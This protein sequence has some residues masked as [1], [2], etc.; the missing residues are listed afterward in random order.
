MA[1]TRISG[2]GN[3]RNII[4]ITPESEAKILADNFIAELQYERGA[5]PVAIRVVDP[6]SV[7]NA[8]FE[9]ALA[10]GNED[11]DPEKDADECFWTLTN[12][13]WLNDDNP[14]NDINAVRTSNEAIA[15]RNEQLLLDWGLAITWEQYEYLNPAS[16]DETYT[17]PLPSTIEF[18]DPDQP[19]F[20]G[21][22]DGEG[23][24]NELNWIR[25]GAQETPD[26]TPEEEAVFDD[27]KP[28]NP[29]DEGETWEGVIF[30]TWAPYCMTSWT[31]DI[32]FENGNT[33]PY[34]TVAPTSDD[35]KWNLGPI[36]DAIPGTNNVDVVMTSDKSL[37]TRCPVF[38]MQPN[39]DL[40]QDMDTPLGNPVKMGLRRHASVDKNG[41][42][43]AEGGDA[44]FATLNGQQ[45][46]GMSWFPGYA[47]DVGTGERLNMA[48]GED[49]WASADNGD[50]MIFNPSSRVASFSGSANIYAGG[51]HWIYVFKNQAYDDDNDSRVPAYDQGQYLYGKFGPDAGNND[52]RKAMRG[53][54]WVGSS[55]TNPEF[56]MLPIEEGLIPTETR[57]RLRVAKQYRRYAHDRSDVDDTEGTANNN[58]PL[59]RFSTADVATVTGDNPT[60]TNALDDVRVVPNPYYAYSQYETSKLDNRVKITGL[61][62][63]CTVR[64]YSLAGT[65]VRTFDKADPLTY[66]E[67][68]L[69]NDRNVPIAGGVH[70]VHVDAPGVGEKI[71]K[72][73][74]VMRPVDLDNF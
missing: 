58:N 71:V 59:Y 54:T 16:G 41:R 47:I 46:F 51:Q 13:T 52:D 31:A 63:V 45:P 29:Y 64:I 73:F 40:A 21:F 56:A 68:D 57:I 62:E 38:E 4:D 43:V 49:S 30:G 28:G 6:L 1:I 27:F 50:D 61:P 5:G 53:C 32:T 44:Y 60:L 14:D 65:L 23:I 74:A 39:E 25:A 22:S 10:L 35:L 11:L 69:K 36:T 26:G 15:I 67:W 34:P 7:P 72:W 2:K 18:A 9:L 3:G 17:E 55:L 66:L 33:A 8:E 19:W 70:I 37:W 20:F 48:F 24:G 12:L 42:T